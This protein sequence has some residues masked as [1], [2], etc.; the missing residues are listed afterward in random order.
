MARIEVETQT[1]GLIPLRPNVEKLRMTFHQDTPMEFRGLGKFTFIPGEAIRMEKISLEPGV[2][3]FNFM[4]APVSDAEAYCL[5][6]HYFKI[7]LKAKTK[8]VTV[9]YGDPRL[10]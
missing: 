4:G 2:R 3:V 1:R 10:P 5:D 7:T 8:Q 9:R 6:Q